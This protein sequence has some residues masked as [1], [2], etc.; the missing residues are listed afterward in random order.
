MKRNFHLNLLSPFFYIFILLLIVESPVNA[1]NTCYIPNELILKFNH[2]VTLSISTAGVVQTKV[3]SI[4]FLNREYQAV[5]F[6]KVFRN[7][8][9][10]D[11]YVFTFD[12]DC[13]ME[14]LSKRYEKNS[15]ILYASPNY[16][17]S[18]GSG[19]DSR[20]N[21]PDDSSF[22]DQWGL[23]NTGQTGGTPD[24]DI[25][26]PEAWDLETG[27][28][29]VIIAILDTGID[30]DHPDLD[31]KIWINMDEI[32]GNGIDD[33]HNGFI[34]DVNGWDVV[35]SDPMPQDDNGHGTH[36]A[37]IAGAHTNNAQGVAGVCW[38][39]TLMPIKILNTV[40][41]GTY[42]QISAGIE[43]AAD[44]GAKIL[45]LSLGSETYSQ[46]LQDTVDYAHNLG[47][48]VVG[49][50]GNFN[51]SNPFY[52]AACNHVL[53]VAALDHNDEKYQLSG[54]GTW[55][56]LCAPGVN[57]QSTVYPDTYASWSGTSMAAPFVSGVAGL[58][59]S[60]NASW[61]NNLVEAQ[62]ERLADN[63]EASNP[64][65][66][67]QLG[68]GRVNAHTC[69][70][71]SPAP[72]ISYISCTINDP[73]PGDADGVLDPNETL[74]LIVSLHN[75]WGDTSNVIAALSTSD[76]Y[77]TI[78]DANS[79]FGA[80]GSQHTVSNSS[81][82]FNITLSSSCPSG[83]QVLFDLDVQDAFLNTWH[84]Q[85]T[86][87]TGSVE[88]S[89]PA[90][91]LFNTT[92]YQ[93]NTY[94]VQTSG[95]TVRAVLTIE[96]GVIVKFLGSSMV[97]SNGARIHAVGTE[98]NPI[99]FKTEQPYSKW[100]GFVFNADSTQ[101]VQQ[102]E[103][104]SI[105]DTDPV[106][107]NNNYNVYANMIFNNNTVICY[108]WPGKF[109]VHEFHG[110][111]FVGKYDPEIVYTPHPE[112][113]LYLDSDLV[114]EYYIEDNDS[115]GSV[116]DLYINDFVP[117][118]NETIFIQNNTLD[119][120]YTSIPGTGLSDDESH[121]IFIIN[122]QLSPWG[123]PAIGDPN[124]SDIKWNIIAENNIIRDP[125]GILFNS[126]SGIMSIL[127][128]SYNVI[129][130]CTE[131]IVN[132]PSIHHNT[133]LNCKTAIKDNELD[134]ATAQND[135]EKTGRSYKAL[136]VPEDYSTIQS[137]IDAAY[138][139]DTILIAD[140]TYTGD[141]NKNL[142]NNG[143]SLIIQSENGP[144]NCIIDCEN[145]GRAFYLTGIGPGL[146]IQGLTIRNG[147]P[148]S[149]NGGALLIENEFVD[150][151]N[152]HFES[153]SFLYGGVGG[154]AISCSSACHILN[155]LNCEFVD[156]STNGHGSCLSVC[157]KTVNIE[158]S[159]FL[160]NS[161][162]CIY[163]YSEN[164]KVLN[165]YM[166]TNSDS[167]LS[168]EGDQN[169]FISNCT[170]SDN[171]VNGGCIRINVFNSNNVEI[172][173]CRITNNSGDYPVL[174]LGQSCISVLNS[175][176][177]L[178]QRGGLLFSEYTNAIVKNCTIV[179]NGPEQGGGIYCRGPGITV[180]DCIIWGNTPDQIYGSP[181][182]TYSNVYQSS[183]TPYPGT[184]NITSDPLF[185]A[186]SKGEY[187]L[188]QIASGQPADSPCLN[189]GSGQ[190]SVQYYTNPSGIVYY[191]QLTTRTDD[192]TDS[193]VVDMGY[194]YVPGDITPTPA[195]TS[196]PFP[197]GCNHNNL[198]GNE[199]GIQVADSN[200]PQLRYRYNNFTDPGIPAYGTPCYN[201]LTRESANIDSDAT[202][203]YWGEL[204]T[205]EMNSEN[206]WPTGMSNIEAIYDI[207]DN[208]ALEWVDFSYWQSSPV[209]DA[210]GYLW[211]LTLNPPSPVGAEEVVFTLTFNRAMYT[212]VTPA[213]TFGLEAPYDQHQVTGAW[214]ID[215]KTWI[216]SFII[217]YFTG[218]GLNTIKVCCAKD[219]YGMEIPEDTRHTFII[220]TGISAV[221]GIAAIPLN[222]G[223]D[224]S[225]QPNYEPDL[226]GYYLY[227]DLNSGV[228]YNGTDA[229]EG[230]SPIDVGKMNA[231]RLTGLTN[232]QEYFLSIRAYDG[233][234]NL[235]F[236][237][238]EVS[239]I[240]QATGTP[241]PSWTPTPNQSQTPTPPIIPATDSKGL[242]IILLIVGILIF[243]SQLHKKCA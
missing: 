12:K 30:L 203:C 219:P 129:E 138:W 87:I 74:D 42:S 18:F 59:F 170:I 85:L 139:G 185:V 41:N 76:T 190:S 186:G 171:S 112:L 217:D 75:A 68:Q 149:V 178:N 128:A 189:S 90:L 182:V 221:Q 35:N 62:M 121:T 96:P 200:P 241:A 11:I 208:S 169:V 150:I 143:K 94:I 213:V 228:P 5:S 15:A 126:T 105:Q 137:A 236:F 154:G 215:D 29:N 160:N 71:T 234:H 152:C 233:E 197:Y 124:Y 167:I 181:T 32:A 225:W 3:D 113:V 184:G 205:Q 77:I 93:N 9:L 52:P 164:I 172:N 230:D 131:G 103:Y 70:S 98:S 67:E 201:F 141:G 64:D 168:L 132:C 109:A 135:K 227:Y 156:N 194:H 36:V 212:S 147:K 136:H 46:L 198:L 66:I 56:D 91:I 120:I 27:N 192:I 110:N 180:S 51:N 158:D 10:S 86:V 173:N 1:S 161:G 240:P 48:V 176:I 101:P 243:T 80:I 117:L 22:S 72:D 99:T 187:Y 37:G 166:T 199:I 193:E 157:C 210:P 45:N 175:V 83:H 209:S 82:P 220:E 179:G 122:N 162:D 28:A 24:A 34:D 33:D 231:F 204:T 43:Y 155:I 6:R 17:A 125:D 127:E 232:G 130:G 140:G 202:Y 107:T 2:P 177:Y 89:V 47:C 151:T 116:F 123:G 195:P 133:I 108:G 207:W 14:A 25:D 97:F 226:G 104:C 57:I 78:N 142:E 95:V 39:C 115:D 54:F 222:S 145:S 211:K 44:N 146:V 84:F 38:E 31:G 61:S 229:N 165:C 106:V 242:G 73:A 237:S 21:Y 58:L 26:A 196:T 223:I 102:F 118:S 218:D 16:I 8:E 239:A 13:D 114:S 134:K 60:A 81:S 20:Q 49:A 235:S 7:S 163:S 148:S 19:G 159:N 53:G 224:I 214:Q 119:A 153:N 144:D 63:V 92:W 191:N 206:T 174:C 188:S 55:I 111:T 238:S 79:N 65:Y 88:Y 23:D 50:A 100:Y 4:D 69:I 183:G 40:G 216:G